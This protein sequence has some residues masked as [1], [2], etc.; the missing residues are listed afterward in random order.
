M[1]L[2]IG[3]G[4]VGACVRARANTQRFLQQRNCIR[5]LALHDADGAKVVVTGET[6]GSERYHLRELADCFFIAR[7][8]HVEKPE[9]VVSSPVARAERDGLPEGLLRVGRLAE[10]LVGA[11]ETAVCVVTRGLKY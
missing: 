11:G 4:Q 1:H 10:A 8:I 2:K 5:I 3:R 7:M 9:P 6:M